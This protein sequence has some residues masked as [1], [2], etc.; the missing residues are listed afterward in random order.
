MCTW[1][2]REN[3]NGGGDGSSKS[4]SGEVEP[5]SV[6]S[7]LMQ[8]IELL[9]KGAV[10]IMMAVGSTCVKKEW[11]FLFHYKGNLGI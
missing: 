5:A 9:K 2:R 8:K 6:D 3:V 11:L 7:R 4:E 10:M 1:R